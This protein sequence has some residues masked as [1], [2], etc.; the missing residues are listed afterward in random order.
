MRT[1]YHEAYGNIPDGYV[2][3]PLDGNSENI[4][5]TNLIAIPRKDYNLIIN[6]GMWVK[7]CPELKLAA[8]QTV[9]LERAIANIEETI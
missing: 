8:I 5:A 9:A 3:T 6:R 1:A 2:V 7:G 4:E